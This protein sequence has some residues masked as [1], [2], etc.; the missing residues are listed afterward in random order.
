MI[1]PLMNRYGQSYERDAIIEWIST[2]SL[3]CPVTHQPM[4]IADL[5]PNSRLRK[6]I[7]A[8]R[9]QQGDD[10]TTDALR[11]ESVI[12]EQE[13]KRALNVL[14]IPDFDQSKFDNI[15]VE[16]KHRKGLLRFINKRR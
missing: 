11:D 6:E 14:R 15:K 10:T 8:W 9:E 4:K 12:T 16:R 5:V 3:T 2:K 1:E 7:L 13:I